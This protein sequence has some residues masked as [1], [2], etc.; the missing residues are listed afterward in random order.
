MRIYNLHENSKISTCLSAVASVRVAT[1]RD[2]VSKQRDK[3]VYKKYK[4]LK[5]VKTD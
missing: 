3:V 5:T 2:E 1:T 4:Q